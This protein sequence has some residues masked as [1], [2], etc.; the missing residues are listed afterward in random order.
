M[1]IVS[2][3]KKVLELIRKE[4][5]EHNYY[6]Q[7]EEIKSLI[8]YE[9]DETLKYLLESERE[10]LQLRIENQQ[11]KQASDNEP[12]S[13]VTNTDNANLLTIERNGIKYSVSSTKK[14]LLCYDAL[15]LCVR[16]NKTFDELN[17]KDYE[18]IGIRTATNKD[19]V[20][21]TIA[22]IKNGGLTEPEKKFFIELL[23]VFGCTVGALD[24]FPFLK[25]NHASAS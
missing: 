3:H 21:S 7:L 9:P 16:T 14:N 8:K 15:E 22:R 13:I 5:G 10:K 24:R 11:L 18:V 23:V 1:E 6:A 4:Y 20:R 12:L 17:S 19:S 25:T 2:R